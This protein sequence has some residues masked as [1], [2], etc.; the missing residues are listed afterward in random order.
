MPPSSAAPH[1]SRLRRDS[2]PALAARGRNWSSKSHDPPKARSG[3]PKGNGPRC[4]VP[5]ARCCP[6]RKSLAVHLA[7]CGPSAVAAGSPGRTWRCKRPRAP[8]RRCCSEDRRRACCSWWPRP[9]RPSRAHLDLWPRPPWIG[10]GPGSH[11]RSPR[12]K[13]TTS[14][15]CPRRSPRR[16]PASCTP[17][18]PW[19]GRCK[20]RRRCRPASLP[21]AAES[22]G[23]S[24]KRRCKWTTPPSSTTCSPSRSRPGACKCR[25]TSHGCTSTWN[26]G[27]HHD[28]CKAPPLPMLRNQTPRALLPG[29]NRGLCSPPGKCI[30]HC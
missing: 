7:M 26:E 19:I 16:S 3:R 21:G 9:L 12:C 24:H 29:D 27:K 11:R 17:G 4:T 25:P 22:A 2:P 1:I 23:P 5:G 13:A 15:S 14:P 8:T 6:L 10:G 30:D 18:S 20:P 28:H